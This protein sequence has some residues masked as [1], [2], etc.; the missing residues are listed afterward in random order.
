MNNI[1]K[2]PIL[3]LLLG[4]F[5]TSL[6]AQTRII[7]SVKAKIDTTFNERNKI[8]NLNFLS[9]LLSYQNPAEAITYAQ[10]AIALSQKYKDTL[11]EIR[12]YR[13]IAIAYMSVNKYDTSKL[14]L[15]K[16][17]SLAK[18][19]GEKKQESSSLNTLGNVHLDLSE[20]KEALNCYLEALKLSEAIKDTHNL[21]MR[22]LNIGRVH[23]SD[24]NFSQAK[25][26][27]KLAITNCEGIHNPNALS[28]ALYNMGR[29]YYESN[30]IDSAKYYYE[31]ALQVE[32][33]SVHSQNKRE[34]L[35][36]LAAIH[37][38]IG[39]YKLA[40]K[41]LKDCLTDS[42]LTQDYKMEITCLTK[43]SNLKQIQ[44]EWQM[45]IYYA[46]IA[47]H[48]ADSI[49]LLDCISQAYQV[50]SQSYAGARN[51]E[52]AFEYQ[53]LYKQ[54][55]DSIFNLNK[56]AKMQEML[57]KYE[58]EKKETENELLRHKQ[59]ENNK[60]INI[61]LGIIIGTSI[62]IFLVGF[63]SISLQRSRK[64]EKEI[65]EELQG[66]N[67]LLADLNII[68]DKLFSIIGHDLRA[69]INSLKS[70]LSLL[71]D[72]TMSEE[73]VRMLFSKLI[74]EVDYTSDLL[75]SLLQWAKSQ[76]Q[77]VEITIQTIDIQKITGITIGLLQGIADKKEIKLLH[78]IETPILAVGDEE[79]IKIIIRNLVANALKFTPKKGE[80]CVSASEKDAQIE[81]AVSDN[82]VGMRADMLEKLFKGNVTTRGTQNEKGTG[83][84]LLMVKDFVEKNK[85]SIR[86][87]SEVGKGSRFILM[88]PKSH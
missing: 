73:Q 72:N 54:T 64:R 79:M 38:K 21:P 39:D 30:N 11:G 66:K 41:Y 57:T 7:D 23:L 4:L 12:G 88:L 10:K 68:K 58:V 20:K 26:Y 37:E 17:I 8:G 31:K 36:E 25:N 28:Y 6:K 46:D 74:K 44:K 50:L 33:K 69:P 9:S 47:L 81:I 63:L 75:E 2:Y 77:G 27:F 85:G 82:G 53:L 60:R 45:A 16:S 34:I 61:Q 71:T 80:V 48:K 51:F 49:Q 52:K 56:S 40:D 84:G 87:E 32:Q 76:L 83:L 29:V 43:L 86:V 65:N 19:S 24:K 62:I 67:Q 55:S 42:K 14:F 1:I 5:I 78:T 15:Q 13:Q 18:K 3:F 59:A 70:I 35:G 22:Y